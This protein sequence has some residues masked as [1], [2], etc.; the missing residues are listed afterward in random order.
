MIF[1]KVPIVK[2]SDNHGKSKVKIRPKKSK[3]DFDQK[4]PTGVP[5]AAGVITNKS[6]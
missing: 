3:K 1:I 2:D 4:H 5:P 6:L